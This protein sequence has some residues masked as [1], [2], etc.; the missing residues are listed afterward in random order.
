MDHSFSSTTHAIEGLDG[1]SRTPHKLREFADG[2]RLCGTLVARMRS[3]LKFRF[4]IEKVI[5]PLPAVAAGQT[6]PL[7]LPFPRLVVEVAAPALKMCMVTYV[8][9]VTG[10][11]ALLPVEVL[12]LL[13]DGAA[14]EFVLYL[15]MAN[16]NGRSALAPRALLVMENFLDFAPFSLT[17]GPRVLDRDDANTTTAF[18]KPTITALMQLA[19]HSGRGELDLSSPVPAPEQANAKRRKNGREPFYEY[20]VLKLRPPEARAP[21]AEP[22][23]ESERAGVRLHMRRG[24][25]RRLKSGRV[26]W[27]RHTVVG[28]KSKGV[29]M[30]D[31]DCA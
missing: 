16:L 13:P 12:E 14:P 5:G 1:L 22:N 31:Y 28:D 19:I 6:Q 15:N 30:K 9:Q 3:A 11:S 23:N 10:P 29:V 26:V 18:Y 25:P 24:H 27:V 7:R 2:E 21:R 4:P 20:H 17:P 8:E